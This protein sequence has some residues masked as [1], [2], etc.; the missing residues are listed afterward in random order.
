VVSSNRTAPT[1]SLVFKQGATILGTVALQYGQ[2]SFTTAFPAAGT[3][4]IVATYSGDQTYRTRNSSIVKQVVNK[5]ATGVLLYSSDEFSPHGQPVTFTAM[6]SS[7]GP[8]PTGKV[9]F[10]NGGATMGTA[11]LAGG[12]A[13]FTK[14]NLPRGTYSI[15]AVYEGDNASEA[16]T[17]SVWTQVIN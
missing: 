16:S 8:T 9:I 13:T 1:G 14:S 3:F 15:T 7:M 2:A 17:S 11:Q 6:V 4:P 5:Y 12:V 10:K